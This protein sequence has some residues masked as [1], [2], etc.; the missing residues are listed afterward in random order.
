MPQTQIENSL[1]TEEPAYSGTEQPN[2]IAADITNEEIL[3]PPDEVVD[4]QPAIVDEEESFALAPVDASAL[5][6]IHLV[7]NL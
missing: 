4:E 3:H 2:V 5:K 6:G 7:I 1:P